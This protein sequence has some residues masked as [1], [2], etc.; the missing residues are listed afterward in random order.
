MTQSRNYWLDLFSWKTWREFLEAGGTV[1]GFRDGRWKTVEKISVGDYLL[2]YMTGISRW[3][4]ILEVTTEPYRDET[5]IWSDAAISCRNLATPVISIY[6][7]KMK[8]QKGHR[9]V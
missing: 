4:G 5:V 2:C 8:L 9:A 3:I 6:V 1:S 7:S